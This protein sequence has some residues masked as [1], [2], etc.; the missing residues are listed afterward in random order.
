[1]LI[2]IVPY[3]DREQQML[4]FNK[5]MSENILEDENDFRILFIHQKDDRP[6]NRG[7]MKNIGFLVVKDLYPDNYKDITLVFNDVDSV[8]YTKNF[9]DYKTK[10]GIVKHFFGFKFALGGILSI[11]ANDFEK[12]N[13]FPNLWTWGYED[14]ELNDR[15]NE[16]PDIVIDRNQ[17]YEIRDKNILH[18]ADGILKVRNK[19]EQFRYLK[20]RTSEGISDINDLKYSFNNNNIVDVTEFTTAVTAPTWEEM[21]ISNRNQSDFILDKKKEKTDYM[22]YEEFAEKLPE[23]P[24]YKIKKYNNSK[25]GMSWLEDDVTF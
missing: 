25:I 4:F 8:P 2:F 11:K 15:I 3:R 9:I 10:N 24:Q 12:V 13:G 7:A 21:E 14:N 1:M 18:A 5:H 20:Q 6:F 17:F 23:K 19:L 16:N 22:V